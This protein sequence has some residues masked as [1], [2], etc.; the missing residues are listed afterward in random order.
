MVSEACKKE[1]STMGL[2]FC[3]EIYIFVQI[4]SQSWE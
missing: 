3:N 1:G 4:F 2:S